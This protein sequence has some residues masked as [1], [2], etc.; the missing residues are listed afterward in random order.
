MS[1][2]LPLAPIQWSRFRILVAARWSASSGPQTSGSWE[3]LPEDR[4]QTSPG[5]QLGYRLEHLDRT[6]LPAVGTARFVCRFGDIDGKRYTARVLDGYEVRIQASP[7]GAQDATAPSWRTVWWGTCETHKDIDWGASS[8]PSGDRVYHCVDGFF[9]TSRWLLDRHGF[10]YHKTID[11]SNTT[12]TVG[13]PLRGHPGYN[14]AQDGTG[15][16]LGNRDSSQW[17]TEGGQGVQADYHTLPGASP[18][19]TPGDLWTELQA[20]SH[21][22]ASVR[23]PN[24][25]LFTFSGITSLYAART[26]WP[27][28]EG[29]DA[30]T[31]V[32]RICKRER[33]RGLV[34]VDWDDDFADPDGPLT[35]KLTVFNQ[36]A[37]DVSF[38]DPATGDDTTISGSSNI[39]EVDLIGDHRVPQDSVQVGDKSQFRVDSLDT[40]GECIE[41]MMNGAYVDGPTGSMPNVDGVAIERAW[42]HSFSESDQTTFLAR[43]PEK[44][45]GDQWLATFQLHRFP[46][47]WTGEA[48]DGDGGTLS[49][50]DYRC[51][52]TG[53]IV[54]PGDPPTLPFGTDADV[55]YLT[56]ATSP[57]LIDVVDDLPIYAGYKYTTTA[58][59]RDGRAESGYPQ[60]LPAQVYL[61][62]DANTYLSLS[63]AEDLGL[64]F[65]MSKAGILVYSQADQGDG[66]RQVSIIDETNLDAAYDY[67]ALV[68]TYCVRLPHRVRFR[69]GLPPTDPNCK[70]RSTLYQRDHHLWLAHPGAIWALDAENGTLADGYPA[71]RN[72]CGGAVGTPGILRDDRTALAQLH[73]LAWSWYGYHRV[74]A[75]WSLR[76]CGFLLGFDAFTGIVGTPIDGAMQ[77]TFISYPILGQI[78]TFLKHNGGE[79][80]INTPI[81]RITYDNGTGLTTWYTDWCELDAYDARR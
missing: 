70:R 22:L 81:T 59:R 62:V 5:G 67:N 36:N 19:S 6:C 7:R 10:V 80:A 28:P 24:E 37:F 71:L 14:A 17:P 29:M 51:T 56:Q 50:A 55:P 43:D 74:N 52:D 53:E 79:D 26:A 15:R 65:K 31:H 16:V 33:G 38:V 4:T 69:S 77:P 32:N 13:G 58:V 54:D 68:F 61:R 78:V 9:R 44:R 66:T 30:R 27:V 11:G 63:M 3:V 64:T 41:V 45:I 60:R 75:Q 73:A 47:G 40:I 25:P 72:A 42:S 49:R 1:L 35:V 23:P 34:L 21:A 20:M 46:L 57:A 12:V 76:D 39:V 2:T 18:T 48:G 8:T